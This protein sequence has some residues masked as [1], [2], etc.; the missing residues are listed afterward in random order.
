MLRTM[1]TACTGFL[2][3]LVVCAQTPILSVEFQVNSF[4]TS[5]QRKPS[6][7]VDPAGNFIVVWQSFSADGNGLGVSGQ[8]FNV[9]GNPLGGEFQVNTYTTGDQN[10]PSVAADGSG[11]FVVVW[12]SSTHTGEDL[13]GIFG[14]R[15][16]SSGNPAGGEF[17]VNTYTTN[18]Q[19]DPRVAMN[20]SGSFVVVW[21]SVGQDGD[22]YGVFGQRYDSAGTAQGSEFRVNTTTTGT[23]YASA[24]GMDDSGAFV[25]VWAGGT[26]VPN[27]NI[28]GQRYGSSGTPIGGEFMVNTQNGMNAGQP[29]IAIDND[30]DFAV[31]WSQ[32]DASARGVF[33]QR[34]H[35]DGTPD[36]AQFPVNTYT[37]GIQTR[38]GVAFDSNHEFVVCW[39]SQGQDDPGDPGGFGVFA[40]RFGDP[41]VPVGSEFQV[42]VFTPGSQVQP[43]VAMNGSGNFAVAWTSQGQDGNGYGIFA[44]RAE[45]HF[46]QPMAVDAHAPGSGSQNLNGVFEPGET[47][48]VEPA[49]LDTLGVDLG[50]FTGSA[51]NFTGPSGPTYTIVD[52]TADYGA[53]TA[54]NTSDCFTASGNCY[55]FS[56][57]GARP[58]AH[59]DATFKETFSPGNAT[60]VWTLHVGE[61][62]P[63]V[64]T[65]QQFYKFIENLFHHGVTGGCG[66]GNYCP[67]S[68]VTRAQMAVFLLKA[69]HGSTFVPPPCTG[70]F[71]DVACPSQFAD[72]IEQLFAEGITG[73]CGG[74]NYCPGNPVTRQQMAVFLLKAKYSSSYVPPACV[75][76]FPDVPCPSQFADWIED[77]FNQG[78]TGGCGGG[79][80]CPTNPNTRGQMAVFLVKTFGLLLYGP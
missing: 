41:N 51:S 76:I 31:A 23:Q 22:S 28:F 3:T 26:G 63:D 65:S 12:D 35:G 52:G 17:H 9:V 16:D 18:Y 74:G 20:A 7:A 73:G 60:K 80:Y 79:N 21:T 69:E 64:P 33:G 75:G 6:I 5:N 50:S 66:G 10:T 48:Q 47:V 77:L 32:Y 72:W 44:R 45:L 15:Y 62:F 29:A 30:G 78:I 24:V 56:V 11:N 4:T 46:A 71:P 59:W 54:G 70:V 8:R 19:Y 2:L 14:Q 39:H 34:F 38:P 57:S 27:Y 55:A 58:S 43:A 49:F 40:Q 37:T 61:S 36:G 1:Y 42:N 67:D 13:D 53:L 25:V 68:S